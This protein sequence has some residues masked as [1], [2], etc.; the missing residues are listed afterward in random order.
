MHAV[1]TVRFPEILGQLWQVSFL[2][3]LDCAV[4]FRAQVFSVARL[5]HPNKS[6]VP[7]LRLC[8]KQNALQALS[9]RCL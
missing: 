2:W 7:L 9:R 3:C 8:A 4:A 5:A 1:G 6:W